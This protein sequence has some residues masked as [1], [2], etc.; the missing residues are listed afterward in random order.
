[1]TL[2]MAHLAGDHSQ[3]SSQLTLS[4]GRLFV[5][6]TGQ[7]P[8]EVRVAQGL[9]QPCEPQLTPYMQTLPLLATVLSVAALGCT[10]GGHPECEEFP[11]PGSRLGACRQHQAFC[12]HAL[13]TNQFHTSAEEPAQGRVGGRHGGKEHWAASSSCVYSGP[14][15]LVL[16]PSWGPEPTLHSAGLQRPHAGPALKSVDQ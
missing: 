7:V 8:L 5:F 1:M 3:L 13:S 11:V 9:S 6:G 14:V 10:Q 4:P 12:L 15:F 16:T 2:A